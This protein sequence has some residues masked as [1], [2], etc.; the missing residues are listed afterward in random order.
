MLKKLPS[1]LIFLAAIITLVIA[2]KQT[3]QNGDALDSKVDPIQLNHSWQAFDTTSWQVSKLKPTESQTRVYAEEVFYQNQ[4][5]TSTFKAPYI[6]KD[7]SEQQYVLQSQFGSTRNDDKITLKQAV[8]IH[9]FTKTD[10]SENRILKTEQITYNTVTGLLTSPVYTE[11][12]QPNATI[13]G[14]G[15]EAN[16]ETGDYQFLSHVK[17]HYQPASPE[18][19][20]A[21]ESP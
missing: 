13:S 16:T 3:T 6:I 11:I 1:V 7:D 2:F 8:V 21:P 9:S 10:Q 14:I 17:T 20:G 19:N 12:I 15:F 4:N 18:K 5:K